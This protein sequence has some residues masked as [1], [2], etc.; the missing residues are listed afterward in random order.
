[1]KITDTRAVGTTAPRRTSRVDGGTGDFAR[2]LAG[3]PS[4]QASKLSMTA[5]MTGV[6]A[7]L[8]LQEVKGDERRKA[9]RRR[10]EDILGELDELRHG[11][12]IGALSR[13]QLTRLKTMIGARR[14]QLADSGLG[15]ILD[16]IELRAAVELAKYEERK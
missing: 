3:E 16:E 12:L 11:L 7:L 4:A 6:D 13:S 5:P 2:A 1:M 9:M 15:E 14:A 10:A 8:S